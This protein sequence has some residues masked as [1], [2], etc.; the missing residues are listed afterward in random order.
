M[1]KIRSIKTEPKSVNKAVQLIAS[2][3]GKLFLGNRLIT[4]GEGEGKTALKVLV[5]EKW[6]RKYAD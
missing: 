2:V 6:G 1:Y 3:P 4:T 5:K